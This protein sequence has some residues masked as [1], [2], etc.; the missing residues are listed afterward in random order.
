MLSLLLPLGR[1]LSAAISFGVIS[2][3]SPVVTLSLA[4]GIGA[5]VA[6]L[7]HVP[8][9]FDLVGLL[10]EIALGVLLGLLAGV[11]IAAARLG[12]GLFEARLRGQGE[13]IGALAAGVILFGAHLD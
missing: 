2:G 12:G 7:V 6:A 3:L 1:L 4:V 5:P 10:S 13:S 9:A 8:V 11:P